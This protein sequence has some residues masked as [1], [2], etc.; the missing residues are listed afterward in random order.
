ME[1]YYKIRD[2][3]TAKPGTTQVVDVPVSKPISP[4]RIRDNKVEQVSEDETK[5]LERLKAEFIERRKRK[6][7]NATNEG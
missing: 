2:K 3:Y 1:L 6:K 4:I 7:Q 5:N